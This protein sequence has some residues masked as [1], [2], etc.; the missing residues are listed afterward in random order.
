MEKDEDLTGDLE[1]QDIH[2]SIEEVDERVGEFE[3]RIEKLLE[4][5]AEQ[6][7]ILNKNM[8]LMINL[9]SEISSN[10]ERK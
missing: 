5:Q 4:M 7:Q 9:L 6:L 1:G 8:D 2:Q 3:N 10:M